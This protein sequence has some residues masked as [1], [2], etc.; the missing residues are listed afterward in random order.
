L[1]HP[2]ALA[3]TV[4]VEDYFHVEA[5]AKTI[6]R[7][8]WGNYPQ[9][10]ERNTRRLLGLFKAF[11]VRGTFFVL[12]WVADR[13]PGLVR[14]IRDAGHE[15]ASHGYD[16]RMI[17]T[18]SLDEFRDDTARSKRVIENITGTGVLGYRAPTFSI[19]KNTAWAYPILKEEG[20]AYSSSVYPIKH[21]RYGWPE[22]GVAP[23]KLA[24]NENGIGI[25]EIPLS[26]GSFPFGNIPFG[27]GGYLRAYPLSITKALFKRC[28]KS[29][30]YGVVYIHPWEIDDG[31]PVVP[32][33]LRDRI[34][35]HIGIARME[36]KLAELLRT[37][38]F[39]AVKDL[40]LFGA[41]GT[42]SGVA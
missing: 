38:R 1:T 40:P 16:H 36:G 33:P 20:Y 21:D 12:G 13:Y 34:R 23:R 42:E 35:H 15:L 19:V 22:F 10:V 28:L 24:E 32:A 39:C 27:G 9:R 11:D 37:F 2:H 30:R 4:D 29:H 3:L 18:M 26:V 6:D 8:E 14:T 25:W 41:H 31:Q 5:F 7:K 17:T